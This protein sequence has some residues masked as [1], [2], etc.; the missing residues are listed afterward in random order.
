MANRIIIIGAGL[1]GTRAAMA[2]RDLGHEGAITLIGDETLAPYDRPPLSKELLKSPEPVWLVAPEL[3]A[4]K[5]IDLKTGTFVAGINPQEKTVQCADGSRLSYDRLLLATGAQARKLPGTEG[6]AAV[7][8]LRTHADAMAIRNS[9]VTDAR[10]VIIGG[11]FIGLELA[12]TARQAGCEV[13][14][15]EA[16]DRLLARAVPAPIAQIIAKRHTDEGVDLRLGARIASIKAGGRGAHV[17][18]EDGATLDADLVIVGI[19]SIPNSD[20][21][22]QAG[23]AVENGIVVDE[24]LKTTDPD[25]LAA[26]DCCNFPL[27]LYDGRRVRLESWRAAQDVGMLAAENLLGANKLVDMVPWFWSDQYDLSLQIAGLSTGSDRTVHRVIDADTLFLFHIADDGRIVA[28]SGIGRGNTVARD[29][30]ICERLI[31]ARVKPPVTALADP[32]VGM[33]SLLRG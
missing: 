22:H 6:I 30:K 10:I 33:K 13:T 4:D 27:P 15:L 11:G 32:A 8:T 26:G 16:Q 19:G 14:I 17:S 3:W 25:I 9:L 29:I 28:A 20:L 5:A 7:K 12:S 23:L 31:A 21:A 1:T 18:L 24:T 2:L